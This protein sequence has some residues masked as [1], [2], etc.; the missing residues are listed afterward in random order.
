[1]TAI[2]P[3][4]AGHDCDFCDRCL[5][6]HC[7][8][9]D[10]VTM[11][12]PPEGSWPG[13][14]HVAVGYVEED[15][16]EG[17]IRCHCCG[18][19]FVNLQQHTRLAHGLDADAYR[20]TWGLNATQP[21]VG[22]HM[23]EARAARAVGRDGAL[24]AK[25][26]PTP[27]QKSFIGRRRFARSQSARIGQPLFTA[28]WQSHAGKSRWAKPGARD[29]AVRVRRQSLDVVAANICPICGA[30]Y[31][32]VPNT[33]KVNYCGTRECLSEIKRRAARKRYQT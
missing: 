31:C 24:L 26:T 20:A 33:K 1:M 23:R 3:C 29:R 2:P 21:L 10:V 12:L 17:T 11:D 8:G 9:S 16:T 7:C 25:I 27:E 13:R 14:H 32:R 5:Q 18:R 6:G 30:V 4:C 22:L 19:W 15:I 28:E